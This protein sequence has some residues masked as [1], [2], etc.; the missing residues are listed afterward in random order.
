MWAQFLVAE[1]AGKHGHRF[2]GGDALQFATGIS[3]LFCGASDFRTASHLL[4]CANDRVMLA[5]RSVA[6]RADFSVD[7]FIVILSI[8]NLFQLF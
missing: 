1:Q 7:V 6:I 8:V 2:L 5:H 3:L 4:S